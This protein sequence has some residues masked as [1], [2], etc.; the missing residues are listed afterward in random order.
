MLCASTIGHFSESLKL[1]CIKEAPI[2]AAHCMCPVQAGRPQRLAIL[3][4]VESMVIA[5]QATIIRPIT[6]H[7]GLTDVAA[8]LVWVAIITEDRPRDSGYLAGAPR[9]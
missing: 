8:R 2:N 4:H 6:D 9:Q 7:M 3:T 1:L 5:D